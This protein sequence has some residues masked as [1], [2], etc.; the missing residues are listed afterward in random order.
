MA[1]KAPSALGAL[2]LS[3]WNFKASLR[4]AFLMSFSVAVLGRPRVYSYHQRKEK[5]VGGRGHDNKPEQ[6][7]SKHVS[8]PHLVMTFLGR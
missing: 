5:G 8:A 3:G 1:L 6:S 2:F 4:Y 7:P